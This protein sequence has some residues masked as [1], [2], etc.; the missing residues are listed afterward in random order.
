[1]VIAT[2]IV[3]VGVSF[4]WSAAK[5]S[6]ALWTKMGLLVALY[7]TISVLR[8]IW[9]FDPRWKYD[10]GATPDANTLPFFAALAF[11]LVLGTT[12]LACKWWMRACR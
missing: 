7:L 3:A 11:P 12:Y 9:P 10:C 2:V 1:M 4:G 5:C 6:S 8:G